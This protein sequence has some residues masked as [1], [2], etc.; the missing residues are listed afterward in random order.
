MFGLNISKMKREYTFSQLCIGDIIL[1]KIKNNKYFDD[2]PV[3]CL[4]TGA[5]RCVII[6]GICRSIILVVGDNEIVTVVESLD[7]YLK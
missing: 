2:K 6:E 4:V 5:N 7:E 3:K 1:Y